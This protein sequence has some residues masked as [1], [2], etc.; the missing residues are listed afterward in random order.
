MP[1][2]VLGA[3]KLSVQGLNYRRQIQTSK[4]DLAIKEKKHV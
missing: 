4:V 3:L 1:I 2:V